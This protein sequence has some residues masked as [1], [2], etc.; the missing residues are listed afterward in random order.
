[1]CQRKSEPAR[2]A[3]YACQHCQHCLLVSGP[4][5]RRC[6]MDTIDGLRGGCECRVD[7]L[8]DV[9]GPKG[10]LASEKPSHAAIVSHGEPLA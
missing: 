2:G 10:R 4:T 8:V 9:C 3:A 1:M 6:V 7:V 5:P